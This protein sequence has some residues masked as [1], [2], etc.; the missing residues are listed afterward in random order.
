MIVDARSSLPRPRSEQEV[1]LPEEVL[2]G[3]PDLPVGTPELITAD[4]ADEP[5]PGLAEHEPAVARIAEIA[6]PA[7]I[8]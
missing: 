8:A 6:E 1:D 4:I 5:P 3:A 7:E 2:A